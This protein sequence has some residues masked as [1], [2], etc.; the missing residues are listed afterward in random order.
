MLINFDCVVFSFKLFP[1][2]GELEFFFNYW[3]YGFV[4]MV[5]V[6]SWR[7][8]LFSISYISSLAVS[9]FMI[10]YGSFVFRI[11][12]LVLRNRF[13]WIILGWDGLGI[14]SF[15]LVVYY[16]NNES[17]R[18]GLFT[19][20]QNRVGDIFFVFFLISLWRSL[21]RQT[22]I[23]IS[24]LILV[25]G[26]CV[27][28]AQFPFNSWL[29]AAI[30][31]PTPVSSL[32]HSST[33]VV[34][35][36][37]VILEFRYCL[38]DVEMY[39]FSFRLLT[40][41]LSFI[42]LVV[43]L[44]LK[45]LIA[46]STINHVSLII[47]IIR[48]GLFSVVYF[49]LNVHAIFKSFVFMCFGYVILSCYHSQDYRLVR[50]H[51]L[52]PLIK[53]MSLFSFMCL[54]GLPFLRAFFSKDVIIEK[55]MDNRVDLVSLLV[56]VLN[57]G[58]GLFYRVKLRIVRIYNCYVVQERNVIGVLRLVFMMFV[59]IFCINYYLILVLGVQYEILSVKLLVYL[60]ICFFFFLIFVNWW[61]V[62]WMMEKNF[63]FFEIFL[64]N[65]NLL[66]W[67]VYRRILKVYR[68]TMV[69]RVRKVVL[70][71]NW[72]IVMSLVVFF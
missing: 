22:F 2:L 36:V 16:L 29:L 67:Y 12:W 8:R 14:V 46:Y 42:G 54:G 52:R 3:N 41:V 31:A 5:L 38:I 45:K 7:V 32:V 50:I 48:E 17:V 35:G 11:L 55:I 60:F 68:R 4:I 53:V 56:L 47:I 21:I 9:N 39:L 13:Y 1:S 62:V 72:W 40:L 37:Y 15:L 63:L 23:R 34:A 25:L 10:I 57:L 49:H 64:L 70:V 43:E 65:V 58:V 69:I 24:L 30:S 28:R 66:D 19:V 44:D 6:I 33:L 18:N 71:L 51:R 20:F 26:C 61:G 27:K 59:N